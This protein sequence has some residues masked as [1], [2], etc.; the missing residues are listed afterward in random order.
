[1]KLK[2]FNQK[3]WPFGFKF[4]LWQVGIHHKRLGIF[5]SDLSPNKCF[6]KLD[7][8]SWMLHFM[9]GLSPLKAVQLDIKEGGENG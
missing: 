3:T 5:K 2:E 7:P 9:Q 8:D 1:M 4:W 6:E